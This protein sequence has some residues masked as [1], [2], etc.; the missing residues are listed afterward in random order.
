MSKLFQG[1]MVLIGFMLGTATINA[2]MAAD[3]GVTGSWDPVVTRTDGT[4]LNAEDIQEYRFYYS[5]DDA[6]SHGQPGFLPVTDGETVSITIQLAPRDE[7]YVIDFA[8]TA[9]TVYGAESLFSN[10]VR[11]TVQV[12]SSADPSAPA[13]FQINIT[14]TDGCSA[15]GV[16]FIEI[17]GM[18]F[19]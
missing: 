11:K 9:F 12:D 3:Y 17:T 7:P 1:F 14:C 19:G 15:I 18:G 10:I 4:S 5:I 13:N 6:L 16:D 2:A 8:V